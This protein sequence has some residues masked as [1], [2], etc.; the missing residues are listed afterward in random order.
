LA[1]TIQSI[2]SHPIFLRSISIISTHLR[3][4]LPSG[5]FPSGFPTNILHAFLVFP[6]RATCHAHVTPLELI[7]LI[8]FGEEYKLWSS[9]LRT[10]S[11]NL[12]SLHLSSVQIFSSAP[13]SQTPSV[14]VPHWSSLMNL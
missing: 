12:P 4:V 10:V 13:C 1:R 2:P 6:I 11:S 14:C 8:M 5:L 9:S 3:H 7:I